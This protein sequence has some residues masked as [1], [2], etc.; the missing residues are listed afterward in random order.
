MALVLLVVLIALRH[1]AIPLNKRRGKIDNDGVLLGFVCL[2][3]LFIFE[4]E[5]DRLNQ[6][7]TVAK[8]N[9]NIKEEE[10]GGE[11]GVG[12]GRREGD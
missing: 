10:G 7:E 1:A 12:G 11:R 3:P 9:K 8:D 4:Q 5:P 6:G 2:P